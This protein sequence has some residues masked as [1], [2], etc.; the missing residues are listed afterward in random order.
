[1]KWLLL[2]LPLS[3]YSQKDTVF[4]RMA[5]FVN[6][7]TTVQITFGKNNIWAYFNDPILVESKGWALNGKFYFQQQDNEAFPV[8]NRLIGY[9]RPDS[10][11]R[12]FRKYQQWSTLIYHYSIVSTDSCSIN[13]YLKP[14]LK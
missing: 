11:K 7:D 5:L 4:G 9:F 12:K 2:L 8:E 10:Q 3:S 14:H 1:M 6:P 13:T